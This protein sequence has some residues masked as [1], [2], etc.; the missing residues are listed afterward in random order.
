MQAAPAVSLHSSLSR[1]PAAVAIQVQQPAGTDSLRSSDEFPSNKENSHG[2]L[3]SD[4]ARG[5][6]LGSDDKSVQRL[7]SEQVLVQEAVYALQVCPADRAQL[8]LMI[9]FGSSCAKSAILQTATS[10]T[11]LALHESVAIAIL[12]SMH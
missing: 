10:L 11:L 3:A 5:P 8:L 12:Q 4:A 9:S 2:H 6:G 7:V 1:A